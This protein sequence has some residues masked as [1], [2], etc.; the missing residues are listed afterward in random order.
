M[1]SNLSVIK[2]VSLKFGEVGGRLVGVSNTR[3]GIILWPIYCF[4]AW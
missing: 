3:P 4:T 1:P 2:S